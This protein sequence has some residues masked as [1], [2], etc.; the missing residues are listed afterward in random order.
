MLLFVLLGYFV[1]MYVW[2]KIIL[3]YTIK[4]KFS[5]LKT[6]YILVALPASGIWIAF[7]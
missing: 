6:S 1:K 5:V 7:K 3:E 4:Y 2:N